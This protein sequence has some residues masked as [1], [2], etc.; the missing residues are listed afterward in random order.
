MLLVVVDDDDDDNSLSA[1][2]S[3]NRE[4]HY[5]STHSLALI[6]TLSTLG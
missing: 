1:K 4:G 6:S 5:F 3:C 2:P